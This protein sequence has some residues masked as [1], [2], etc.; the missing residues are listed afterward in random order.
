MTIPNFITLARLCAVP[1]VVMFML[2][3][4]YDLAFILFVAAGISDAIDGIIAR[5]FNQGSALGAYLDP[6]ADKALL[7]SIYMALGY[8]GHIP[9]WLI[10]LVVSRDL[11]IIGGVVLSWVVGRPVAI[12]P[13]FVSKANTAVQLGFAAVVLAGLGYGWRI[14]GL[15]E[16]GVWLVAA[17]TLASTAAY[18]IAWTRHMDER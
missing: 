6:L 10:V 13:I 18:L 5:H 12:E 4:R 2:A 11:L 1:A 8:I 15:I 14:G 9:V 16:V 7:V 17:L 3:S